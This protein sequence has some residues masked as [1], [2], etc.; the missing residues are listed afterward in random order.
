MDTN[1]WLEIIILLLIILVYLYNRFGKP[2]V[3][4]EIT[5]EQLR[6]TAFTLGW[7]SNYP[8]AARHPKLYGAIMEIGFPGATAT[9]IAASDGTAKL[10]FSNG[11]GKAGKTTQTTV[12]N[13]AL[14]FINQAQKYLPIL[15]RVDTFPVPA[16]GSVRFYVLTND[17]VFSA[18]VP[19]YQLQKSE[20]SLSFLYQYGHAVITQLG[21][22]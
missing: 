19:E 16:K 2:A 15:Q 11:N 18:E 14:H 17:G 10:Y 4:P 9:L 8:E 13:A 12:R 3:P 22:C 1:T 20:S 6:A 5:Y 21:K 7:R